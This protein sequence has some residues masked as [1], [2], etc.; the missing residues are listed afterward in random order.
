MRFTN[1]WFAASAPFWGHSFTRNLRLCILTSWPAMKFALRRKIYFPAWI[2][3][4]SSLPRNTSTQWCSSSSPKRQKFS[5]KKSTKSTSTR[6]ARP[7]LISLKRTTSRSA[8]SS[9]RTPW[10]SGFGVTSL[11]YLTKHSLLDTCVAS[12]RYLLKAK[13]VIRLW[14]KTSFKLRIFPN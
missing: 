13:N 2:F 7:S 8:K 10:S 5:S 6:S 1:P 12:G 4:N 11:S 3:H 14:W 9:S